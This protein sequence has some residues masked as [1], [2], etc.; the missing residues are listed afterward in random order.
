MTLAF[1][2]S[3]DHE[4]TSAPVDVAVKWGDATG[5]TAYAPG[6]FRGNAVQISGACNGSI[7]IPEAAVLSFGGRHRMNTGGANRIQAIG[8]DG[9]VQAAVVLG[10]DGKIY[11]YAGE[12]LIGATEAPVIRSDVW[13][14]LEWYLVVDATAGV[15]NVWTDGVA[16]V[17][18]TGVNT[19]PAVGVLVDRIVLSGSADV[20]AY[21]DDLYLAAGEGETRRGDARIDCLYPTGNGTYSQW[22]GS[23]TDKVDNYALIDDPTADGA[24]YVT[25]GVPGSLETYQHGDLGYAAGTIHGAQQVIYAKKSDAGAKKLR[26]ICRL[27]GID[28]SG[29]VTELSEVFSYHRYMWE[30]S[31]ATGK[32]WTPAEIN[33]AEFG[34][35]VES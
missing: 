8:T 7:Y 13:H 32:A 12:T 31:P 14:Y 5:S 15:C 10:A 2:D 1:I 33:A 24:D 19:S 11:A 27:G 18:V 30:T 4:A 20:N 22:T 9:S 3:C 21:W 28:Y 34:Y 25:A 17:A 6:G 29:G 35:K 16:A 26:F 23:D